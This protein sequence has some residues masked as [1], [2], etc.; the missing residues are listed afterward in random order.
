M[1]MTCGSLRPSTAAAFPEDQIAKAMSP[2]QCDDSA[3]YGFG[4]K[5]IEG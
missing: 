4:G 5:L 3:V 2:Q 1:M